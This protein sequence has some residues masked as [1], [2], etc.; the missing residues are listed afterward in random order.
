[1]AQAAHRG[2]VWWGVRLWA[3]ADLEDTVGVS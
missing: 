2:A 1:M 3:S